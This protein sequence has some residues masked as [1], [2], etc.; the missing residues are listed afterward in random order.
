MAVYLNSF[1]QACSIAPDTRTL[2]QLLYKND[3]SLLVFSCKVISS[4]I[5]QS[6]E[7]ISIAEI[8]EVYFGKT[9]LK[10]VKIS[11]GYFEA[12]I[13]PLFLRPQPKPEKQ[14]IKK[15]YNMNHEIIGKESFTSSR[16]NTYWGVKMLVDS[17]YIIYSNNNTSYNQ[18]YMWFS[19]KLTQTTSVKKEIETLKTF[20][21][22][23][24]KKKSGHFIFKD[25]K[26]NILAEGRYKK[27]KPNGTWKHF[28]DKG[29][30]ISLERY[31]QNICQIYYLNGNL[32][33]IIK[34]YKDSTVTENYVDN[35]MLQF[36]YKSVNIKSDT[37]YIDIYST[38]NKDGCIID[39]KSVLAVYIKNNQGTEGKGLHGIYQEFYLNGQLKLNAQYLLNRRVGCWTWY[40]ENGTFWAE[41]DYKDGKAPQ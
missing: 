39:K 41:W 33:S 6:G 9:N 12:P 23:F 11:S 36:S 1:S 24:S 2:T 32:S 30:L 15:D 27:G 40:N 21:T 26:N 13:P 19:K 5:E 31:K 22:I 20:A 35:S 17:F 7:A 8:K 4:Y 37:G 3:N 10:Q 38:F 14:E 18:N 28:N 29:I 16:G 34:T 25:Y